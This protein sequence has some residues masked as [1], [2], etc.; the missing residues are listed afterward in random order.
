[1][2]SV[3]ATLTHVNIPAPLEINANNMPTLNCTV[4]TLTGEVGLQSIAS[5]STH[6]WHL[7]ATWQAPLQGLNTSKTKTTWEQAKVNPSVLKMMMQTSNSEEISAIATIA[8]TSNALC[9]YTVNPAVGDANLQLGA[10]EGVIKSIKE[11]ASVQPQVP[12]GCHAY[13]MGSQQDSPTAYHAVC[14]KGDLMA[15]SN[16]NMSSI[17]DQVKYASV[18]ALQTKA[19]RIQTSQ[20]A[21]NQNKV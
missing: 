5:Q 12:V 20:Q 7:R 19:M 17:R 1:M 13:S 9:D 11:N 8:C 21:G 16:H 6:V 3:K 2:Q 15:G 14:H 10:V 18:T 4:D